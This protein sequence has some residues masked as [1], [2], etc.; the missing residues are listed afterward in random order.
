M[1]VTRVE[2]WIL[3]NQYRILE[4]LDPDNAEKHAKAHT[5]LTNGFELEYR[6]LIPEYI[7]DDQFQPLS[8]DECRMV[9]RTVRMFAAL[10]RAYQ[11][12]DDEAK[13]D[14][15]EAA[16]TFSGFDANQETLHMAYLDFVLA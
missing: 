10:G 15:E 2:R 16:V 13:A 3:S 1:E 5:I 4:H 6:K 9:H 12:L 14:I 7:Y 11:Q 8:E